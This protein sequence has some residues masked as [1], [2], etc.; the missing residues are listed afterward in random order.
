MEN[1]FD[2]IVIGGGPGGYVAAI[3]SAKKGF[4][5]AVVEDIRVGG[6]CLNRGCIPAKAMIH[7]SSLYR[8]TKE[9]SRFGVHTSDVTFNYEEILTY[10][11]NTTDKLVSGVEQLLKANAV[12]KLDGHGTL[13]EGNKVS[14][15]NGEEV[16]VYEAENIII[17]T[18][19]KPVIL[20][21]PGM[22]LKNVLTSDEL[23]KLR[24]VPESL[25]I[26]G[27]GVISVEFASVFAALGTTV[28]IVEAMPRLLPNMDKE[29]SQNLKMIL[30]KRGVD[31]HVGASVKS[32]SENNGLLSVNFEEKGKE[33]S[34]EA[35]YVLCA[36]GRRPNTEGLF[37]ENISLEMD[38]NFIK[39]DENFKTSMNHVYA[40]GD[41]VRGMQ[42]AHVASAQGVYVVEKL[43]NETPSI[44]LSA[45]PGC[46]Y[47]DPEIAS[48]GMSEEEAKEKG[49][50]VKVGKFIMSA[51]GKSLITMEERGFIKVVVDA[52]RDV[53]LGA[54]MMCARAT[55]MIGE[56]VTA[57]ANKLTAHDMLKGMRAH[58]TYNEGVGEA[59]EDAIGEAIHIA[60][61]RKRV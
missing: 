36:V 8:E 5:T 46:V 48:V 58:P 51:N 16:N 49:I 24:E 7:A 50:N 38:R 4:K 20:P 22:D 55:D 19:S 29:I 45:V 21:L 15:K 33:V 57:V 60:P 10:K 18:G 23:F 28:T 6:T 14:V 26:I 11:E 37:G 9:A 61:K 1:K 35:Q 59:L 44:D 41:V 47:T 43:A 54:A 40:I 39:V 31:S 2:V 13:E 53:I 32:I 17:A 12:T 30:K 56:F 34:V 25:A 42:L 3:K 27:G 52:E